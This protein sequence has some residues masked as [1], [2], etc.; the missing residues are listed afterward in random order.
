MSSVQTFP[1]RP[2]TP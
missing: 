1:K 2:R